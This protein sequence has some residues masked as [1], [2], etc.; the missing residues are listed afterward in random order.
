MKILFHTLGCKVNQYETQAMMAMLADAGDTVGEFSPGDED[1]ATADALVINSCTVTAESDRKLR[2]LVRRCRRDN[3]TALLVVTGCMPQAFPEDGAALA[4]ADIVMGNADRHA[5]VDRIHSYSAD[6]DRLVDIAAH[7]AVYEPLSIEQFAGRTRAF[8][9]IEDGCN[10]FCSYCI[11]PYAR[12]RVRSRTP[13]DLTRELTA[14]SS[15]GYKEVVL[16]GINL[17]AYGQDLGLSICDAVDAACSVEGIERVRLGSIEPDHLIPDVIQRLSAQKKL[18]PQFHLS[19]QSGCDATLKRMNRHY[20]SAEY[21]AVCDELRKAFPGCSLTTD[22]MVGFPGEDEAEFEESLAFVQKIGFFKAHVFAY[23]R[24]PGTPAAK[25]PDQVPQKVKVARSRRMIEVGDK[26][27]DRQLAAM[28]GSEVEVLLETRN[29]D[30]L[31]EG[32]TPTYLP[33]FCHT[34]KLPGD[35]VICRL[36]SHK[37]GACYGEEV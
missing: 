9:K 10:R 32:Y 27:R 16:V 34:D 18:C 25:A 5:V 13:E 14:L 21:A 4:D 6:S 29:T 31:I 15:A 2:Q 36:T 7:T 30:G 3:P 8:V 28:M 12:G 1:A 26:E 35:T 24:R 19:L 33:V 37:D 11:I 23:S 17:T 22:V 20:T